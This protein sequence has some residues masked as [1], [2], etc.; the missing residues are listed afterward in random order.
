[1]LYT[2]L[3][4]MSN[5]TIYRGV[6]YC[7]CYILIQNTVLNK[8]RVCWLI[9]NKE[10]N[11]V[12]IIIHIIVHQVISTTSFGADVLSKSV[13]TYVASILSDGV[14]VSVDVRAVK[15]A[16]ACYE[17]RPHSWPS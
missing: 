17:R 6:I 3:T 7:S 2:L 16:I 13:H 4:G 5:D 1:M 14:A 12:H 11:P 8:N 9:Y 10:L 15:H